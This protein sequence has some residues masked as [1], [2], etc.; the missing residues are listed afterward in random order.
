MG[1]TKKRPKSYSTPAHPWIS[2]RMDYEDNLLKVYGLKGKREIWRVEAQLSK[3]RRQARDIIG[4]SPEI[5]KEKTKELIRKLNQLGIVKKDAT[6]EDV[7]ALKLENFLDRR[8]QT[9]VY[10]K[11]LAN[12][13]KQ[14]RQLI[15]HGHIALKGRKHTAPNTLISPSDENE[16]SYIGPKARKPKPA[17]VQKAEVPAEK[18]EGEQ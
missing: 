14:A 2:S 3:F 7:L 9:I 8:F 18:Q 17:P 15:L 16:I 12:D 6:L 1:D 13:P 4:E 11:G 5:A 10:K